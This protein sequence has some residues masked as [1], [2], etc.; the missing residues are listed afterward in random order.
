MDDAAVL[1]GASCIH[2]LFSVLSPAAVP[3]DYDCGVRS[4][5]VQSS[6]CTLTKY[7]KWMLTYYKCNN[8]RTVYFVP[9]NCL[10]MPGQV[11]YATRFAE[12]VRTPAA[13]VG[14]WSWS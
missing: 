6:V 10:A 5:I 8:N 14:I 13:T 11:V 9:W 7:H 12:D 4:H 2:G 3:L 1:V